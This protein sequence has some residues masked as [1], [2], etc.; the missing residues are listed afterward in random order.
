MCVLGMG[1]ERSLPG[2]RPI[3]DGK[4]TLQVQGLQEATNVVVAKEWEGYDRFSSAIEV[5]RGEYEASVVYNAS[6]FAVV[7]ERDSET[8]KVRLVEAL[9]NHP[10]TR[11]SLYCRANCIISF[12]RFHPITI[13]P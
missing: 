9:G 7:L 5:S 11:V 10:L 4:R 2:E 8:S 13:S 6:G 12:S 3:M 1:P